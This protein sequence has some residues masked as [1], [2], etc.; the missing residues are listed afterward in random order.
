MRKTKAQTKKRAKTARFSSEILSPQCLLILALTGCLRLLLASDGGLLISLSLANLCDHASS[1]TLL[2]KS[3]ESAFERFVVF[4]SNFS[5]LFSLPSAARQ[6]YELVVLQR[7]IIQMRPRSVKS[8][9][10]NKS[11]RWKS[12]E[13]KTKNPETIRFPDCSGAARQIRTADLILTKDVL[14]LLSHSS[15]WRPG[16]GSNRRPL[17]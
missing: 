8:I 14:C 13:E 7:N 1:R 15:I 3:S 4:D 11:E 2:L 17:A 10:K 12:F 5:H 9:L 6:G 16:T